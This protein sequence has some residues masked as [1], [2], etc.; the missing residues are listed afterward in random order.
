MKKTAYL[1]LLLAIAALP[2]AAGNSIFAYDGYP[3]QYFGKDIYSLGM[4][5]TGA[6][7]V[8]RNN[9]GYSNPAQSNL[10]NRSLFSTG[11]LMGYNAYRSQD[12]AGKKY[13]YVDNSLDLP[14]FSL[15]IPLKKH[16]IGFQVNSYASGVVDNQRD[17]ESEDGIQ[18]LEKQSMDRYLYR[19]DLIYSLLLGNNSI[20]IS[21]NYYFGHETRLL[22]QEGGY[23]PFN[24]REELSRDFKNPGLTVG[25][26]H[27]FAKLA[28]GAHFSPACTLK[29]D[30]TR[31]SIHETETSGDY[32]Y[33]LPHRA[34]ASV[35]ALPFPE[36]K[37][38]ADFHYE[39]WDAL[40]KD[41]YDDS[42]KL[43]VGVAYEPMADK[44]EKF[45]S[46][47]PLRAGAAYRMLPFAVNG[48]S[49]D[50][51]SASLGLTLPLK[52]EANRID[53]GFQYVNR[54]SLA[55]NRLTDNSYLMM[56]GFTGFDIFSKSADRSAPREIPEKED[57]NSW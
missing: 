53:I 49:V 3:V 22:I 23:E 51:I 48:K 14:Y 41:K 8:F 55:D 20:G 47:L 45:F 36:V 28:L 54:G 40:D 57:I 11:L 13:S 30:S 4:G 37:V 34:C 39:A 43:G 31:T 12:A 26:L 33:E 18:Y 52:S 5:D 32:E 21:G 56:F 29:G 10:S 2:L 25:Y 15:S 7:D 1:I 44:H 42:W 6:S 19:A 50:E 16:R 27:R 24:T 35:T 46:K 17:M 38:A 9:T